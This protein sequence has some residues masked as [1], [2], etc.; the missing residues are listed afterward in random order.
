[1]SFVTWLLTRARPKLALLLVNVSLLAN[2]NHF[3]SKSMESGD[4]HNHW[5]GS[6]EARQEKPERD[7]LNWAH[8]FCLSHVS[9][10][11]TPAVDR[12]ALRFEPQESIQVKCLLKQAN[13]PA[14]FRG[15][16]Q[17]PSSLQHN[18]HDI[19]DTI[20]IT[21][22]TKKQEKA[23][24]LKQSTETNVKNDAAFGTS[25]SQGCESSYYM[26]PTVYKGKHIYCK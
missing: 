17:S 5:K 7:S 26:H 19:L 18:I 16:Q 21:H 25:T 20:N 8:K 22:H 4:N 15:I 1:M 24:I 6:T 13:Q 9:A 14:L 11:Q 23:T 10:G 2:H 12:T 3:G